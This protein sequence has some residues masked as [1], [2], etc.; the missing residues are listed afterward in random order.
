MTK[1]N[2]SIGR[3]INVST[4]GRNALC[5]CGSGKKYKKCHIWRERQ[6]PLE[7]NDGLKV[8]KAQFSRSYCS[9]PDKASCSDKII[10]AHTIQRSGV[11]S[12]IAED[13]HVFGLEIDPLTG[14]REEDF[15]VKQI[16][17][18][19]ATT[20]KGFCGHHDNEA[21]KPLE[22]E[23]FVGNQKQCFLLGYRALCKEVY[24][25]EAKVAIFQ[26]LRDVGDY[27]L[28]HPGQVMYQSEIQTMLSGA[29][30]GLRDLRKQKSIFDAALIN[31]DYSQFSH[32]VIELD[33]IPDVM[34][35]G[36]LF[37][38][39]S[40]D[41]Q[42]I[43]DLSDLSAQFDILAFNLIAVNNHGAAVFTWHGVESKNLIFINSLRG[44][45]DDEIPHALVRFIFE[46]F[47]NVIIRPSWW[48]SLSNEDRT[49]ILN[50]WKTG[51]DSDKDRMPTCLADDG[52]KC[53]NWKV[54]NRL[55]HT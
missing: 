41:A 1:L 13:G 9:H 55:H 16:G 8:F 12:A 7:L 48:T 49:R 10:N 18:K 52:L 37:P 31:D 51:V 43:C 50:R 22:G 5:W 34:V 27:G 4:L 21:F 19:K 26:Y 35:N 29:E 17:V 54:S 25:A 39:F 44:L 46:H 38:E 45:S 3:L 20:F 30:L 33:S 53:V 32:Y 2:P 28:T 14:I 15:N 11:I 6:E 23:P 47:E 36:A 24:V 40:F 42:L